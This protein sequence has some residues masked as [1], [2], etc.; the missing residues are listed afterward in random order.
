MPLFALIAPNGKYVCAEGGG[1]KD[2]K[3]DRSN[4]AQWET[5]Q[6]NDLGNGRSSIETH[7]GNY[8][9][10]E[11]GGGGA[12][13][14]NRHSVGPWEQFEFV[15]LPN[16]EVAIKSL[17]GH[18]VTAENAGQRLS[19]AGGGITSW[20]RFRY[21]DVA[22]SVPPTLHV[23][24]KTLHCVETNDSSHED[25]LWIS[26][27]CVDN[28]GHLEQIRVPSGTHDMANGDDWHN[29]DLCTV[30]LPAGA[31]AQLQFTLNEDDTVPSADDQL[32]SLTVL[33]QNN[34]GTLLPQ[35]T[36]GADCSPKGSLDGGRTQEFWFTGSGAEYH[37]YL[38]LKLR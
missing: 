18:Y 26:G 3:A 20:Q 1:M 15:S 29:N 16:G 19:V 24:L 10:A 4:R 31:N 22:L 9:C 32:G 17:N 33:V 13:S 21:I 2:V 35:W 30:G 36:P 6:R 27:R 25:E 34:N 37:A 12:L 38:Q 11:Q 8:W 5:F 28:T 23:Q 7:F 14:A